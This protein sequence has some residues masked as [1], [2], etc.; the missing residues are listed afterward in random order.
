MSATAAT[1]REP[2]TFKV[3]IRTF[4]GHEDRPYQGKL[5]VKEFAAAIHRSEAT[6]YDWLSA[7][8]P[9]IKGELLPYRPGAK[10]KVWFFE[11]ELAERLQTELIERGTLITRHG[12][13]IRWT[14]EERENIATEFALLRLDDPLGITGQILDKAIIKALPPERH[15][16]DF[17]IANDPPLRRLL[18]EKFEETKTI[19]FSTSEPIML[20]SEPITLRE[21]IIDVHR[22]LNAASLS[23]LCG[24]A[25]KRLV[26]E[27]GSVA[28]HLNEK[29]NKSA[30]PSG[31]PHSF[32]ETAT[33]LAPPEKERP[34]KLRIGLVGFT[35]DQFNHVSKRVPY[36]DIELVQIQQE[37]DQT[38]KGI[39][40]SVDSVII[41]KFTSH[42]VWDKANTTHKGRIHFLTHTGIHA[43]HQKVVELRSIWNAKKGQV[44]IG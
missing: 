44:N 32:P 35:R 21:A 5:T 4:K 30:L 7:D 1:Q 23:E 8:P 16:K 25:V 18:L 20:Q 24:T 10:R 19:L 41:S 3:G 13:G 38:P 14:L 33:A 43:A 15:R 9:K 11:K 6:I 39:P 2:K 27:F 22:S 40:P 42:R 37:R 29:F 31:E 26:E 34:T 28:P 12:H 36:E 17:V